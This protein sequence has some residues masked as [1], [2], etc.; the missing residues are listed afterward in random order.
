MTWTAPATATG[1]QVVSPAFWNAQIPFNML[2]QDAA[3]AQAEGDIIY[4]DGVNSMG[5]R[6]PIGAA[7]SILVA[8]TVPIWG[9]SQQAIGDA[10]YV[11]M[12]GTGSAFAS[13]GDPLVWGNGDGVTAQENV[14]VT[15]TT[16][17]RAMLWYGARYV[18]S[19]AGGGN[20]QLSYSVSG[21]TT[22]AA[23]TVFGTV[24]ESDPALTFRPTG[25]AHYLTGLTPGSNTFTLEGQPTAAGGDRVG[26]PYIIVRA[27]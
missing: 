26:S 24:A 21:A 13:F 19:V 16:G 6:L 17:T 14:A 8:E 20:I 25:R 18:A 7:R 27:L 15:L 5:G 10:T 9:F 23:S 11:S 4:A 1:S 3:A 2:E 12:S 22:T